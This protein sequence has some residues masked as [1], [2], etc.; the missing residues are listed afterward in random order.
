M[1]TTDRRTAGLVPVNYIR[2]IKPTNATE[3]QEK[4]AGNVKVE[5]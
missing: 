5:L 3:P 2:I 4:E 1:A